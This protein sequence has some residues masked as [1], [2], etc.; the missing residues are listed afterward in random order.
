LYSAANEGTN[1]MRIDT[2]FSCGDIVWCVIGLED[3]VQGTV[4]QVRAVSTFSP[5]REGEEVFA[6]YKPQSGYKEEYMCVETGIGSGLVYALGVNIFE[7]EN[8]ARSAL[9]RAREEA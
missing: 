9:S 7:H 6:N 1:P 2:R 8:E 4:G 3:V 5:G